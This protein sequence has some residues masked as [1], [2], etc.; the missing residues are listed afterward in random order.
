MSGI[1]VSTGILTNN[2]KK[3]LNI[4]NILDLKIKDITIQIIPLSNDS[5]AKYI[6]NIGRFFQIILHPMLTPTF[7]HVA[8]QL[9]M[10]NEKNIIVIEYGQYL[11]EESNMEISST[12][13]SGSQSSNNPRI[14]NDESSYWYINKDGARLTKINYDY[15]LKKSSSDG[16]THEEI[17][18]IVSKIIASYHYGISYEEV[19]S[20]AQYYTLNYFRVNC[21]IKEKMTL[22]ELLTHFKDKK[23]NAE[24]YCVLTNNCQSFAAEVIKVLKASRKNE[25]TKVRLFEKMILPNSLISA[26]W[27]NEK[28]SLTNTIG[29]IP[30]I[31][32]IHD[33][34][35]I[36]NLMN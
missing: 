11:S 25:G 13:S 34:I 30:I 22:K 3:T 4:D 28:L 1:F 17:D 12:I 15:I 33:L 31:G 24:S 35:I 9:N 21:D 26:L 23:W 20:N 32:L 36:R 5:N 16:I 29:R 7:S 14:Q 27:D 18:F 2:G 8:I 10:E 19:N 6:R